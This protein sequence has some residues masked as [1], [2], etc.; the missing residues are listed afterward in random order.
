IPGVAL[1]ALLLTVF[2]GL[3]LGS[4]SQ[5]THVIGNL[6][7]IAP[8]KTVDFTQANQL[9]YGVV[10]VLM[11]LYRRQGLIPARRTVGALSVV[12]QTAQ[13]QRGGFKPSFQI[14]TPDHTL[15]P[16]EPL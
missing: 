6:T 8:L 3:V 4:L 14:A 16:G 12:E 5:W 10:L 7:N 11:M 15:Q 9:I 2:Q 1:G 13:A